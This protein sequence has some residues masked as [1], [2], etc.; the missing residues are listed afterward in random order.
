MTAVEKVELEDK[1]YHI[2]FKDPE[3]FEIIRTPDWADTVSDSVVEGSE[4]RMGKKGD[5]WMVESV[6]I[7]EKVKD[8][9][10]AK[11]KA[12]KIIDKINS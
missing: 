8:E 7:P 3:M 11:E 1:Y 10:K 4:V 6:L 9:E 5:E 2:R 12:R